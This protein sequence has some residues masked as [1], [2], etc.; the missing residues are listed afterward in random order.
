MWGPASHMKEVAASSNPVIIT[1]NFPAAFINF[2]LVLFLGIRDV[3]VAFS[4]RRLGRGNPA[5]WRTLHDVFSALSIPLVVWKVTL[6]R[7]PFQG[8]VACL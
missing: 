4:P 1:L 8:S 5:R 6:Q 7:V 2:D 3:G